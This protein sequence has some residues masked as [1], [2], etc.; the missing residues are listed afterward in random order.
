ML[1]E[2]LENYDP[3]VLRRDEL[4]DTDA[5]IEWTVRVREMKKEL[6]K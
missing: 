6:A 4:W 1:V 3:I 2:R 5:W